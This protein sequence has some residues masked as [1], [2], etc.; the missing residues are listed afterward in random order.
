VGTER[1][2]QLEPKLSR[3]TINV[4]GNAA[5]VGFKVERDG[6]LIPAAVFGEPLPVDPGQ[7]TMIA[8][9]P[10]YEAWRVDVSIPPAG[11]MQSISIPPLNPLPAPLPEPVA[12]PPNPESNSTMTDKAATPTKGHEPD[13]T[14]VWVS[15]GVGVVGLGAGVLFGL[16]ASSLD[17]D[18]KEFCIDNACFDERGSNLSS[19]AQDASLI[20]NIGYGVGVVGLGT[21]VVLA[22]IALQ[23]DEPPLAASNRPGWNLVPSIGQQGASLQM[24][25]QF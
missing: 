22:V 8:V 17:K 10:G 9:A 13:L 14:W 5:I 19:D 2:K 15:G 25:G 7:H 23:D 4:G 16:Q 24:Q 3:V 18:A 21:A 12:P 6:Q 1:A 11:G 20:A